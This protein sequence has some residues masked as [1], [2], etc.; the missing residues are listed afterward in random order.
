VTVLLTFLLIGFVTWSGRRI[1][2]A[3]R[4]ARDEWERV[5]QERAARSEL[6]LESA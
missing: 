2:G 1:A 3:L 6:L 4:D 5:A